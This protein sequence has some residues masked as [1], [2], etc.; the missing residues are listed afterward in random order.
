MRQLA[1]AAQGEFHAVAAAEQ[2]R[3]RLLAAQQAGQLGLGRL[4]HQVA[5]ELPIR[6][7]GC[8]HF[9]QRLDQ[10]VGAQPGGSVIRVGGPEESRLARQLERP[11]LRRDHAAG[12]IGIF[13]WRLEMD[14]PDGVLHVQLGLEPVG[15]LLRAG[16]DQYI[17]RYSLRIGRSGSGAVPLQPSALRFTRA[18]AF[19]AGVDAKVF[20]RLAA[21]QLEQLAQ[22]LLDGRIALHGEDNPPA[23]LIQPGR[24][25]PFFGPQRAGRGQAVAEF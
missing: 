8:K 23:G 3:R 6:F 5:V 14:A 12:V 1:L 16:G 24:I 13:L 15:D 9:K 19:A 10:Q 21:A 7:F 2:Q 22:G 20:T 11:A 25:Y 17:I 4:F 18:V